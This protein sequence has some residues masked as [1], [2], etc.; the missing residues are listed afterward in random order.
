MGAFARHEPT[1]LGAG[2]VVPVPLHRWREWKR[3]FNQSGLLAR[4]AARVMGIPYAEVLSRVRQTPTQTSLSR[5]ARD[6]NVRGAFAVN[7]PQATQYRGREGFVL[8][9]DD[10]WTTGA[11]VR[12][13]ARAL[14]AAGFGHVRALTLAR[15][16]R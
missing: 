9:V 12:E 4:H 16:G 13:C 3:G 14:Q 6:S 11:T 7:E 8:L 15:R 5:A 2:L 10:V 1:L